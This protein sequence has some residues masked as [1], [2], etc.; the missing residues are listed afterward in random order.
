MPQA[1]KD[2][3]EIELTVIDEEA[4][5]FKNE[6]VRD[7]A[8]SEKTLL[9]RM[10]FQRIVNKNMIRIFFAVLFGGMIISFIPT[11]RPS[12][13][14][15]EKRELQKFPKFSP[16][17]LISGDYFDDINLWFSDTF[18]FRDKLVSLNSIINGT[19]GRSK[20]QIHGSVEAG[21][22]VPEVSEVSEE[23]TGS[24]A[25]DTSAE[26]SQPTEAPAPEPAPTEPSAPVES[27]APAAPQGP[28]VEQLGAILLI[29][30]AGYEYYNFNQ[31]AADSYAAYINRAAELLAGKCTVYD[32]IVPTSMAITAPDSIA[33]GVNSS[34]QKKAIDYM[35][36]RMIPSV[37]TVNAYDTLRAHRSEYL[38]F[39][40]DHHWTG[41]GAYYTYSEL[42]NKKGAV[43]APLESFIVRQFDGFLGSFYNESGKKPQLA[44]TPDSVIAYQP[45][46]TNI[47]TLYKRDGS[48]RTDYP[49]ILDG[50]ALGQGSKYLSFIGGDNPLTVMENPQLE[51]GVCIAIKESF[52]N[53]FVPFL[54][55]NYR[56]VYVV[57]YRYFNERDARRLYQLADEVGANDV[58]FINNISATR[59]KNLVAAIGSFVG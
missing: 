21:D 26:S 14:E 8:F 29:D 57:D 28:V 42:M 31:A 30:N 16:S 46:Q 37:N 32:I 35:Y 11:L 19:F 50:N 45:P 47:C 43:A 3:S 22:E 17:A 52:G 24:E 1:I 7:D 27:T 36:S 54:T 33:A 9:K 40:T 49:I 10:R 15:A 2:G 23:E 25:G 4:L 58:V 41:L 51:G 20:V 18:P 12:Y 39:R 13:S 34:D 6:G 38:Y 44:A 59:N 56:Y 5:G 53:A 55:Q 48:V